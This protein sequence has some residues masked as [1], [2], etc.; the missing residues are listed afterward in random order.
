MVNLNSIAV[1]GNVR[2]ASFRLPY[3]T[4]ASWD[5]LPDATRVTELLVRQSYDCTKKLQKHEGLAFRYADG[6]VA[7]APPDRLDPKGW[8]PVDKGNGMPEL[9]L[10]CAYSPQL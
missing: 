9:A 2:T 4:R 6:K 7:E 10:V 8:M 5:G 3:A 1:S